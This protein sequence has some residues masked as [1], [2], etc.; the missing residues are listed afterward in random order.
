[1]L[2]NNKCSLLLPRELPKKKPL[3]LL[4][5][6]MLPLKPPLLKPKLSKMPLGLL[7]QLPE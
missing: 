4:P 3:E 1:M 5:K 6:L 7:L 2:F